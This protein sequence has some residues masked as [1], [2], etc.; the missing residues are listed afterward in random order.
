MLRWKNRLRIRSMA[1]NN[2]LKEE[3]ITILELE[4]LL[5]NPRYDHALA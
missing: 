4:L 2:F 3:L 5:Y 1:Q